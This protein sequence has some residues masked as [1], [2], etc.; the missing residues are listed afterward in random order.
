MEHP[1]VEGIVNTLRDRI[2]ELDKAVT[3]KD[4]ARGEEL[5]TEIERLVKKRADALLMLK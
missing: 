5:C 2:A 3:A 1:A 4:A